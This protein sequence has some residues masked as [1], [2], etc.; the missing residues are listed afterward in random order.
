MRA[1]MTGLGLALVLALSAPGQARADWQWTKW[2]MTQDQ[3]IA[4]SEGK[5]HP[6]AGRSDLLRM[7]G[8][9][10]I[11]GFTFR[12]ITFNFDASGR[13]EQVNLFGS[14]AVFADVSLALRSVYGPP[15]KTEQEYYEQHEYFSDVAKGNQI[16]LEVS[17]DEVSL[18]YKPLPTGF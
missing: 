8:A 16:D 1:W 17:S 18:T 9:F 14:D 12:T 11:G 7:D 4:A 2:G 6:V 3:L 13:L 15:V 10:Q 5:A